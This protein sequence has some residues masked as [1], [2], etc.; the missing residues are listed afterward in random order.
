MYSLLLLNRL[1][2]KR[3]PAPTSILVCDQA[4]VD[5]DDGSMTS[6]RLV[7]ATSS[8]AWV[9]VAGRALVPGDVTTD[10]GDRARRRPTFGLEISALRS[11]SSIQIVTRFQNILA[12]DVHGCKTSKS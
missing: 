9:G 7:S 5:G 8:L 4:S 3:F 12:L 11:Q 6:S 10:T 2:M 1:R